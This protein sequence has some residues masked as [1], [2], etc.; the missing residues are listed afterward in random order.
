MTVFPNAIRRPPIITA[1][2]TWCPAQHKVLFEGC[3]CPLKCFAVPY[4]LSSH[5]GA[6]IHHYQA[7]LSQRRSGDQC[8]DRQPRLLIYSCGTPRR[9]EALSM[10]PSLMVT[11]ALWRFPFRGVSVTNLLFTV[12]LLMRLSSNSV[13]GSG[14]CP[15]S[16]R[17]GPSLLGTIVTESAGHLSFC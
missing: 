15:Q 11:C 9:K 5:S 1:K 3:H 17:E 16:S 8:L 10:P 12:Q 14:N 7:S 4:A 6:C 2:T 13:A